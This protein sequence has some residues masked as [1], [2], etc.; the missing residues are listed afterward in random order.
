MRKSLAVIT[1]RG[2]L[3]YCTHMFAQ[4]PDC[5]M[6]SASF[7]LALTLAQSLTLGEFCAFCELGLAIHGLGF[8]IRKKHENT[9]EGL[10]WHE[11]NF[12]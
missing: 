2:D 9:E 5:P 4:N 12:S 11:N 7:T 6:G 3:Y 1:P 10:Y 8:I